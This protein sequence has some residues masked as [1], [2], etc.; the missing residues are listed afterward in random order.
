MAAP[1]QDLQWFAHLYKNINEL[2]HKELVF[3]K[4]PEF[5]D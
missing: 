2:I 1:T 4:P 3:D 5:Q